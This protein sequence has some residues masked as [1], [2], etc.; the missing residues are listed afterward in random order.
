M[1]ERYTLYPCC[2]T[3]DRLGFGYEDG[4]TFLVYDD[5]EKYMSLEEAQNKYGQENIEIHPRDGSICPS[6]CDV[7]VHLSGLRRHI[8]SFTPFGFL[9]VI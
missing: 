4:H 2:G 3:K 8:S 9:I 1:K 5:G 6:C 7:A